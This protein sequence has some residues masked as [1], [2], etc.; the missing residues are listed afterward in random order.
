MMND[1]IDSIDYGDIN[2]NKGFRIDDNE[3]AIKNLWL[4]FTIYFELIG[5]TL[6]Y[7]LT[8][9]LI[10]VLVFKILMILI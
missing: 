9:G 3:S 1:E 7:S 6:F 5:L 8:V 2:I 4:D 10:F